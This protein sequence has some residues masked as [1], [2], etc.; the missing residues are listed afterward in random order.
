MNSFSAIWRMK[1]SLDHFDFLI[2]N[3]KSKWSEIVP[4]HM[5]FMLIVFSFFF[6]PLQYRSLRYGRD[7]DIF[8]CFAV[9]TQQWTCHETTSHGKLK[10]NHQSRL[11]LRSSFML[12]TLPYVKYSQDEIKSW[13][14][15][16]VLRKSITIKSQ[17]FTGLGGGG[18]EGINH[19]VSMGEGR[20]G[21]N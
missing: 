10:F 9:M 2:K 16:R 14:S 1:I 5:H 21:G 19:M 18:G 8:S 20:R 6:R 13:I 17:L 12:L 11:S 15:K 3:K 7:F 4:I